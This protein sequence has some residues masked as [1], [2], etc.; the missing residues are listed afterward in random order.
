[1]IEISTLDV[2]FGGVRALSNVSARLDS[3]ITGLV[4]PNG[5]GKTTLLNVLS[6]FVS[7]SSGAI[8]VDDYEMKAV[9]VHRR[10][11]FG[12]RR[13]F[14]QEQI[15][16]NLS[17]WDNVAAMLDHVPH[18]DRPRREAI[19]SALHYVGLDEQWDLF[20]VELTTS[21]RRMLEIA[22]CIVGEPKLVMMDEPGAGL[23]EVEAEFLRDVITGIPAYCRAQVLL[24]DH[25]IELI[26]DT[27]ETA[28]VLD[29]GTKLAF[30]PVKQI[31][32][33]PRVRAAYLGAVE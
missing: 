7:P 1:M 33:D 27:C 24:V 12:I 21:G 30:G 32:A 2:S 3:A 23:S 15:V 18:G 20:G 16:H 10:A 8:R 9:P 11:A 22:R 19:Q 6:G 28:L 31:L 13:T 4:G 14:Q 5:A 17:V 26:A 29:F 25:D